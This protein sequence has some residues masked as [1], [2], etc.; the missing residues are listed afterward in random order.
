MRRR[1]FLV[2]QVD[3]FRLFR[4]MNLAQRVM[5]REKLK[6]T[7]QRVRQGFFDR[8]GVA[9]HHLFHDFPH[10]FLIQPISQRINRHNPPGVEQFGVVPFVHADDF[11]FG[12]NHFQPA[13]ALHRDFAAQHD[14]NAG[15][16]DFFQKA[17]IEPFR[18]KHASIVADHQFEDFG[19]LFRRHGDAART[20]DAIDC[21]RP[22][23]R[24]QTDDF[25]DMT[26]VFIASRKKE[27]RVF[28][29]FHA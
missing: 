16:E 3:I 13:V 2:Q 9:I 29:G 14:A 15:R 4:E 12:L 10:L 28:D 26:A 5:K 22:V 20:H 1:F 19:V 11:I 24:S 23:A 17:L 7:A 8:C 27:K 21:R 18:R 6:C 25:F